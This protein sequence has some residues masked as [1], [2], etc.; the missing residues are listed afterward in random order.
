V[1]PVTNEIYVANYSGESVTV[2]DGA[3]DSSMSVATGAH[4]SSVAINPVTNKIYIANQ[5]SS[6]MTV[7]DGV[8]NQT[9]IM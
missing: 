8:S 3:I 9:T 1:N 6:N 5:S 2:I 7:I 4:P